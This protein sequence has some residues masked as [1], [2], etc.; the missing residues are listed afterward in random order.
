MNN[1]RFIEILKT[2][3]AEEEERNEFMATLANGK[4]SELSDIIV[5][6]YNYENNMEKVLEYIFETL[7]GDVNKFYCNVMTIDDYH[8]I[9]DNHSHPAVL[10]DVF[11]AIDEYPYVI[12]DSDDDVIEYDTID[13]VI[14]DFLIGIDF[15]SNICEEDFASII[16]EINDHDMFYDELE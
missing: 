7:G 12:V 15:F 11:G 2:K 1:E 6:H 16:D 4:K 14:S 9:V 10:R 8:K 3:Y 5:S 13:E